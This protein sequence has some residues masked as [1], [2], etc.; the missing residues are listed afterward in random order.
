[1][2]RETVLKLE[3]A[4]ATMVNTSDDA[5]VAASLRNKQRLAA[6]TSLLYVGSSLS[7]SALVFTCQDNETVQVSLDKDGTLD[8]SK[9]SSLSCLYISGCDE[10]KKIIFAEDNIQPHN[11]HI[12]NCGA[13]EEPRRES[14]S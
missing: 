10:V 4:E 7:G 5:S 6:A 2:S 13:L 12:S 3:Q 14:Q 1:L 11:I 9:L 8:L